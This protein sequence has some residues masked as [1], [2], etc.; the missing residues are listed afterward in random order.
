MTATPNLGG[1]AGSRASPRIRDAAGAD[2]AAVRK[3]DERRRPRVFREGWPEG[4]NQCFL[5]CTKAGRGQRY[6]GSHTVHAI[7]MVRCSLFHGG[8]S[9]RHGG[10]AEFIKLAAVLLCAVW[11]DGERPHRRGSS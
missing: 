10:D 5:A 8:K 3:Q 9:F 2:R 4:R 11:L 1:S 6:V 7:C